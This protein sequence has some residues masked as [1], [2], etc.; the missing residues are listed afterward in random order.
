MRLMASLISGPRSVLTLASLASAGSDVV[1][2][3]THEDNLPLARRVLPDLPD[4]R[5]LAR[6]QV[7]GG[8]GDGLGRPLV[9]DEIWAQ[10][11]S[12]LAAL[13]MLDRANWNGASFAD[14]YRLYLS[15]VE[16]WRKTVAE[17]E[18]DACWFDGI[19]HQA[20]DWALYQACRERGVET[21]VTSHTVFDGSPVTYREVNGSPL[22]VAEV[23]GGPAPVEEERGSRYLSEVVSRLVDPT[24]L[25]KDRGMSELFRGG[26]GRARGVATRLRQQVPDHYP[27]MIP[28]WRRRVIHRTL[29]RLRD[30]R[31]IARTASRLLSL[32]SSVPDEGKPVIYFPLHFQPEMTSVP[33]GMPHFDQIS[34][35]RAISAAMADEAFLVVKEHPQMLRWSAGW[36]RARSASFYQAIRDTP[37]VRL[38]SPAT[39][40]E[41]LMRRAS[42]VATLTGTAGYEARLRG[43]ST[44]C[45][46]APWYQPLRGVYRA[47][48]AGSLREAVRRGLAAPEPALTDDEVRQFVRTYTL[49]GAWSETPEGEGESYWPSR[50]SRDLHR[51]LEAVVGGHSWRTLAEAAGDRSA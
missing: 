50:Y 20:Q 29:T 12:I 7:R 37:G 5:L 26:L 3:L 47:R 38:V 30:R 10:S 33:L 51:V 14:L 1:L 44:I 13:G 19:P 6:E 34:A 40:S 41:D 35:I 16:Q 32:P 11:S 46:G 24:A 45:F 42:V 43:A 48:D 18:P 21:V 15:Y 8:G 39:P 17:V 4:S 49:E 22:P 31:R 2:L 28:S 36:A 25:A 27:F 23:T 9:G